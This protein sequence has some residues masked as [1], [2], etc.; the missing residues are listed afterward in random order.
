MG[1]LGL[2]SPELSECLSDRH[3]LDAS[4]ESCIQLLAAGANPNDLL[5]EAL[6]LSSGHETELLEFLCCFL[7]L[8]DLDCG[9][10]L[11]VLQLLPHHHVDTV[12]STVPSGLELDDVGGVDTQFLQPVYL[13]VVVFLFNNGRLLCL[14]SLLLDGLAF[15]GGLLDFGLHMG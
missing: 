10:S 2:A 13:S 6:E 7:D 3:G 4:F 15:G 9:E 11:Y 1:Q 8:L 5:P 14:V 12:R